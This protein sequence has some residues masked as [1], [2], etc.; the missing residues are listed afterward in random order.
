MNILPREHCLLY[1]LY[2]PNFMGLG[3]V[4]TIGFGI[5]LIKFYYFKPLSYLLICQWGFV[6]SINFPSTLA[7]RFLFP[8]G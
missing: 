2:G 8:L 4:M 6:L 3:F 1:Y 5:S 7:E